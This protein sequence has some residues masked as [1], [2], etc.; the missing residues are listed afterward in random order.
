MAS[1]P[2]CAPDREGPSSSAGASEDGRASPRSRP[3]SL[4]GRADF[5]RVFRSGS[6]RRKGGVVV[7]VASGRPGPARVGVIAERKQVGGAVERNRAKRRLREALNLVALRDGHDYVV[8]GGREVLDAP[9][10]MLETWL[11][12]AVDAETHSG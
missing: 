3:V 7:I 6:R 2:E 12:E 4:R 5:R 9:F 10:G 8:I 1:E 11:R